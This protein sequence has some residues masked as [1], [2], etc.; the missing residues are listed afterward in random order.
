MGR[1]FIRR[2]W[3]A[4]LTAGIIQAAHQHATQGAQFVE[5]P[6]LFINLLVQALYRIFQADKL[7]F[8]FDQTLFHCGIRLWIHTMLGKRLV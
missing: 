3:P 5:L 6:A 8:Y 4:P 1:A 7:E 2:P